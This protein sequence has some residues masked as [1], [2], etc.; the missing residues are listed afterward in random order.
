MTSKH[1][2]S[3][4]VLPEGSIWD[5]YT[6]ERLHQDLNS[7][8]GAD[9]TSLVDRLERWATEVL[10]NGVPT[11]IKGVGVKTSVQKSD[12]KRVSMEN[13]SDDQRDHILEHAVIDAV[14]ALQSRYDTLTDEEKQRLSNL[15][16]RYAWQKFERQ[17]RKE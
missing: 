11:R 14:L 12:F 8:S 1:G 3:Y 2:L 7:Y 5:D 13:L 4:R 17:N 10:S 16:R 15:K 9:G 6:N